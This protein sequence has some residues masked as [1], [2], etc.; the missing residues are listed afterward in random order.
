[1]PAIL[2]IGFPWMDV[3]QIEDFTSPGKTVILNGECLISTS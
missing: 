3:V 1:M 2:L